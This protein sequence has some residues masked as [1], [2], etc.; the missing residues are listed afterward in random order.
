MIIALNNNNDDDNSNVSNSFVTKNLTPMNNYLLSRM[1]QNSV[2][3]INSFLANTIAFRTVAN[4]Y[5]ITWCDTR[6]SFIFTIVWRAVQTVF[7]RKSTRS[8]RMRMR[9]CF[10]DKTIGRKKLKQKIYN[11]MPWTLLKEKTNN[12]YGVIHVM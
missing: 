6:A 1:T 4:R 2:Q 12:I 8:W 10:F 5:V 11:D 7:C 3:W 9:E